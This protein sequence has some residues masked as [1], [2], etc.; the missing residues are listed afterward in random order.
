MSFKNDLLR[1]ISCDYPHNMKQKNLLCFL[2]SL[3]K[4][5]NNFN[6]SYQE[7]K[8]ILSTYLMKIS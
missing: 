4:L 7:E 6:L 5:S 3:Q 1:V 2:K 8:E